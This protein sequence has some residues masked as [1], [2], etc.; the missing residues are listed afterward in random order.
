[1]RR[2]SEISSGILF[3]G[4]ALVLLA[5]FTAYPVFYSLI[6]S[7]Q[8]FNLASMKGSW[9]GL[10]NYKRLL[11]NP[12]VLDA[13]KNGFIWAFG[14]LFGQIVLGV[15]FA[16]VLNLKF[17]LR[18][19]VRVA[20]I[21]PFFLPNISMCLTWRWMYFDFN[22]IINYVLFQTGI[23]KEPILWLSSLDLAMFSVIVVVVWRYTPFVVMN[24]LA[25]LVTI[26]PQLYEAAKIDGAGVFRRFFSITLPQLR[27]VLLIVILLR[28]IWMF[29]KFAEIHIITGGGPAGS[30]T[31]LP[32]LAYDLAF[33]ALQ[34][35][36]GSAINSFLFLI[37][38][39]IATVY[40]VSFKP[41]RD[42]G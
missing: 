22:G 15:A 19:F 28:G 13:L 7:F 31:T 39:T 37:V 8:K 42:I 16:L 24:V 29:N 20:V 14:S 41:S 5:V 36:E 34:V 38:A 9:Y 17:P 32:V 33:G 25:R 4:P 11:Q 21:L 18:G 40:L 30:T 26:D 35:G 27:N 23:I 3:L 1:M 6:V 10:N 12:E 2:R